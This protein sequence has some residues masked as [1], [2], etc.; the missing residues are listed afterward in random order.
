VVNRSEVVGRP[1]AAMLANDGA[2]VYS[3]DIDSVYIFKRGRLEVPPEKETTET[4]VPRADVVILGVPSASYKMDINLIKEGAIVLNVA[5]HKNIDEAELL[6]KVKN[7]QY[8]GQVG[9]VTVAMLERN[10]LRLHNNFAGND[11]LQNWPSDVAG[12][13]LMTNAPEAIKAVGGA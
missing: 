8:V 13:M 5:S 3:V 11:K 10:L 4:L 2:M 12:A 1:L 6:G 7:V 9:K